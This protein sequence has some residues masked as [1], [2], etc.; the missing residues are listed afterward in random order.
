MSFWRLTLST[1]YGPKNISSGLVLY[2]DSGNAKSY[3]G[4][5]TVN[6]ANNPTMADNITDYSLTQ[7]PYGTYGPEDGMFYDASIPGMKIVHQTGYSN[8]QTFAN[9]T[10]Y[11]L[12]S[13]QTYTVSVDC[14]TSVASA[15]NIDVY[16]G[17]A[18]TGVYHPG[19]GSWVRMTLTFTCTGSA[20]VRLGIYTNAATAWFKNLQVEQKSHA[21]P[22]VNGTRSATAGWKDL[23]GSGNNG[24]LD[25]CIY[26]SAA[27]LT[28]NGVVHKVVI[29]H[30]ANL[31]LQTMTIEAWIKPTA[32][33]QAGFIF[34]KGDVN[35]QY[36][37]FLQIT[38]VIFRHTRNSDSVYDGLTFNTSLLST[39]NWNHIVGTY[40]PGT[41]K[42]YLNA[43]EKNSSAYN[44]TLATSSLDAAI[45]AFGGTGTDY[46]FS[47]SIGLVK[48]YNRALSAAEVLQNFNSIKGR[49]GV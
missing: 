47:G 15:A 1:N 25:N 26:D 11:G 32:T 7:Y 36:S 29:P 48:V 5:P 41:K 44:E 39:T 18:W 35:T 14:K 28:F 40:A 2:L 8:N 4:E 23:S 20:G 21:T 3:P 46:P 43:V 27:Q 42:I 12:T 16:T 19:T 49:F 31:N 9:C 24:N 13:G 17:S 38:N 22:F 6:M 34:E 30:N 10:V 37:L 33:S 45:G